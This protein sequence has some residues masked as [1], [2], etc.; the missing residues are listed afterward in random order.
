MTE[1]VPELEHVPEEQSRFH[2]T[3]AVMVGIVAVIGA[4]L[5]ILE[6]DAK[7]RGE[8][9]SASGARLSVQ[10]FDATTASSLYST[11]RLTTLSDAT[12]L[13]L[14]ATAHKIA[15]LGR[16]GPAADAAAAWADAQ[17]AA[18]ARLSQ[19]AGILGEAPSK[20]DGV[21]EFARQAVASTTAEEFALVKLQNNAVDATDRYG[22]RQERAILGLSLVVSAAALLG[23]GGIVGP[24]RAGRL[25]VLIALL[26][27]L[28]AI[29]GGAWALAV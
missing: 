9:A 12:A 27:M 13:A 18:S 4:L 17:L 21:D 5:V 20:Q 22:A 28:G 2:R 24:R 15:A 14:E 25:L 10:I 1:V 19:V 26:A 6:A 11:F 7:R 8:S 29:G 23:L 3:V 16:P